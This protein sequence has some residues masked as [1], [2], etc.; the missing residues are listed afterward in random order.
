MPPAP[1]S[2]TSAPNLTTLTL[3]D[4]PPFLDQHAFRQLVR[5]NTFAQHMLEARGFYIPPARRLV[6]P[7][8]AF[9]VY[10]QAVQ[11][12]SQ[13]P[14]QLFSVYYYALREVTA[15]EAERPSSGATGALPAS[16]PTSRLEV[17]A[18]FMAFETLMPDTRGISKDQVGAFNN[19][20]KDSLRRD[21]YLPL[22]PENARNYPVEAFPPLIC[23]SQGVLI[24]SHD[25]TAAA[26]KEFVSARRTTGREQVLQS[27][28]HFSYADLSFSLP[29]H[30][31]SPRYV[32][33]PR[34]LR[35]A[36]LR[37][38]SMR[39]DQAPIMRLDDAAA[40][41]YG[42][43]RGDLIQLYRSDSVLPLMA[44]D[45]LGYRIVM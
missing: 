7:D 4:A 42:Y 39:P 33:V 10:M 26:E 27:V 31:D 14:A 21:I 5:I 23:P 32:L 3:D 40:N 16:A 13:S 2:V 38:L 25:L 20:I 43:V 35:A 28:T 9:R 19:K 44:P 30:V 34:H 17:D 41:Y 36:K 24:T 6:D 29:A 1:F 37:E 15:V 11:H 8:A 12:S 22:L 18:V 45:N